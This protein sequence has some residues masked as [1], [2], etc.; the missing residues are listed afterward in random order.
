MKQPKENYFIKQYEEPK[1]IPKE[2]SYVFHKKI[3]DKE[4][5][6]FS[7][8]NQLCSELFIQDKEDN[9]FKYNLKPLEG[10]STY[11][12]VPFVLGELQKKD[13]LDIKMLKNTLI[14]HYKEYI[15]ILDLD[16]NSK[17]KITLNA[18]QILATSKTIFAYAKSLK[19]LYKYNIKGRKLAQYQVKGTLI[20]MSYRDG[21]YFLS[22]ISQKYHIYHL[23]PRSRAGEEAYTE[24]ASKY[25]Q[26]LGKQIKAPQFSMLNKNDFILR[27]DNNKLY[28]I[29]NINTTTELIFDKE[30]SSFET[31]C[32]ARV[33]ILSEDN[34]Y[35]FH[36]E[37]RYKQPFV[38]FEKFYSFEDTTSWHSLIIEADIPEGTRMEVIVDTQHGPSLSH[39]N[40]K[41]FN[42]ETTHYI[43]EKNILLYQE[44]G[45]RLLIRVNLYSDS[46]QVYT[47][48]VHA[49]KTLF[50]KSSYLD[51]LPAYYSENSESLYRFLAVFQ[52]LMDETSTSIDTLADLLDL[53]T[54][55]DEY[56]SWLS[57]WLGLV[58][59]YRWPQDKWRL[60]LQRAPELYQKAGT[61]EGLSDI[62]EL[63]SGNVPEIE[64]Y[65]DEPEKRNENPFFFCVKIDA[66]F[67]ELEI[68][69]ITSIVEEFKP[70]YTQAKV[71]LNNNLKDNPNLILNESVLDYNS[72]IK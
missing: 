63:Y 18:D 57:Q 26:E 40:S 50:N 19:L 8:S 66:D 72:V 7:V 61:K 3:E 64:E 10:E 11:K 56:L 69:V 54:T 20:D 38:F 59:D 6:N 34:L 46:T 21:L 47:P 23:N 4:I 33:W 12:Q 1:S 29:D 45:K 13:L 35:S 39:M 44:V 49:I 53:S 27:L 67:S 31:D 71:V 5:T 25:L 43:N 30:I 58:R 15:E 9:L 2:L 16:D 48:A 17:V 14:L 36:Q 65:M 32:K 22:L 68:A 62:I 37:I 24:V 60:F 42:E 41:H 28:Y 70:A 55:N 52:T 51:Y